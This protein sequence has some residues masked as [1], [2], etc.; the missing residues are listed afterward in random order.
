MC[1]YRYRC[2][3][4]HYTTHCAL[5]Q[6]ARLALCQAGAHALVME[7]CPPGM[8]FV[9]V[10]STSNWRMQIKSPNQHVGECVCQFQPTA[11][12]SPSVCLCVRPF[13]RVTPLK[14]TENKIKSLSLSLFTS[15]LLI[16]AGL[17]RRQRVIWRYF[18]PDFHPAEY[19]VKIITIIPSERYLAQ[20][21]AKSDTNK[22]FEG[23]MI[24]IYFEKIKILAQNSTLASKAHFLFHR[25]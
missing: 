1:C 20:I 24:F 17:D 19:W 23:I 11:A 12:S 8:P 4:Y 6:C 13:I 9:R 21:A 5:I 15:P 3:C 10:E 2:C 18:A 7:K 22:T 16:P 14:R 25:G